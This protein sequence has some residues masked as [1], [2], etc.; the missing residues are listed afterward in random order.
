MDL[1]DQHKPLS[2]LGPA[3]D[4][5]QGRG[6]LP[7]FRAL[8]EAS[9]IIRQRR[10]RCNTTKA[11]KNTVA[12]FETAKAQ[13]KDMKESLSLMNAIHWDMLQV[14]SQLDLGITAARR[15]VVENFLMG[16]LKHRI[17]DKVYNP[18]NKKARNWQCPAHHQPW[19]GMSKESK[20]SARL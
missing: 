12:Q 3:Q 17:H 7:E 16:K 8:N 5:S 20:A 4:Q 13:I 1:P 9:L 19:Q 15:A 18:A 14:I 11:C 10:T 2:Q 6:L